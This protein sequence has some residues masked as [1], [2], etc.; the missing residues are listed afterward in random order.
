MS[1]DLMVFDPKAAPKSRPEFLAWYKTVFQWAEPHSYDDPIVTT[2]ELRQWFMDMIVDFPAI[3]GPFAIAE[4]DPR[5]EE[6]IITSYNIGEH[7]VY[8]CFR[9]SVAESAY[10]MM[11]EQAKKHHVGFYDVSGAGDIFLPDNHGNYRELAA[12]NQKILSSGGNTSSDDVIAPTWEDI[13]ALMT[14]LNGLGTS[15]I[16]LENEIGDFVQCLGSSDKL[17]VEYR[18]HSDEG[19]Q[20]V[21]IGKA[22]VDT[23]RATIHTVSGSATVYRNEI[24]DLDE[25]AT[26][27]KGFYDTNKIQGDYLFRPI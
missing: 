12:I 15:F 11:L 22:P 25:L 7:F 5:F 9:W 18:Y 24:F 6:D 17:T 26:I 27:F 20:H 4:T 19:D 8:T 1:Y 2:D 16:V 14:K 3:N 13:T 10:N 23:K 21:V